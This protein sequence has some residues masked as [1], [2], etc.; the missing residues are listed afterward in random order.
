MIGFLR[1]VLMRKAGSQI[2]LD[3]GGVGYELTVT[4]SVLLATDAALGSELKL[5]VYTDVREN[6][7]ALFGFQ[8]HAEKELF[9]LLKKVKGVGSRTA[10]S[11]ISWMRPE[12]LLSAIGRGDVT[13]LQKVPGVGKKTAERL[14]VELREQV[15]LLAHDFSNEVL[16]DRR[17][18]VRPSASSGAPGV[19]AVMDSVLALEK[20]GFSA[21]RAQSAVNSALAAGGNSAEALLKDPGELL[22]AAL[23]NL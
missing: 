22:R 23:V 14:I 21:E 5:V 7:I 3:V 15:G 9:L 8:E 16:P 18:Q 12:D 4:A 11:I 17:T 19:G 10:L 13:E 20:L 2:L 6:A 1:G